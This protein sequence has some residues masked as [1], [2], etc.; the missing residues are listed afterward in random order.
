MFNKLLKTL[1][2]TIST[3]KRE[4]H[5]NPLAARVGSLME[6]RK[7]TKQELAT[8][9]QLRQYAY[10]YW[11]DQE[12]RPEDLEFML[13]DETLGL[14]EKGQLQ[15]SLSLLNL[16]Q[17]IRG[18]LKGMGG[19][20]MVGTYPEAR[21]RGYV[22]ALMQ[23]AFSEMQEKGLAVSMLEPFKESFYARLGYVPANGAFRL[24]APLQSLRGPLGAS[25]GRDWSF[26]RLRGA[27]AKTAFL[28]FITE[29]GPSHYH[30]FAIR[31]TMPEA[32]WSRRN[33]DVLIVFVKHQGRVEGVARYR[34][35]GY[36]HFEQGGSLEVIEMHWRTLEAQAALFSFFAQ[37][38]DQVPDIRMRLPLDTSF[39]YWF[40]D[41]PNF[42]ELTTWNPWMVRVVD[43]EKAL[44]GLPVAQPGRVTIK[45]AD[46]LCKWNNGTFAIDSERRQLRVNRSQ[47]TPDATMTI[48][49]LTALV[50]ATH[51]VEALEYAGWLKTATP[52]TSAKLSQWFP[53]LPLYNSLN[54]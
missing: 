54:Y 30:G 25:L 51:S 37:H 9:E 38:K 8:T 53:V 40:T 22:K 27:Q 31:P 36:M 50:Y 52:A 21:H 18:V 4:E 46:P 28:D 5:N 47:A 1:N 15:S 49:G 6:I 16:Q 32:E 26:E 23:A 13:P 35:K 39:H 3:R 29:F 12:L 2:L 45:V 24:K 44:V 41:L 34:I 42:I 43:A 10:G 14:F 33:K 17:S 11:S 7:I 19:I 48:E 20:S